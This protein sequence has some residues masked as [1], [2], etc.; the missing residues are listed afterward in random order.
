MEGAA[1]IVWDTYRVYKPPEKRV[2][3]VWYVEGRQGRCV[4]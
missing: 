3:M 1:E 4:E 2:S